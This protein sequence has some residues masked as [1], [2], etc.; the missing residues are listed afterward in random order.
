MNEGSV[1]SSHSRLI[2]HSVSTCCGPDTGNRGWH[3]EV[4]PRG[5][6]ARAD[7]Y[8][9]ERTRLTQPTQACRN[10]APGGG[11]VVLITPGLER[12]FWDRRGR[13]R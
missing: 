4:H 12:S 2:I 7:G 1:S 8:D 11:F 6:R 13:D 9:P 3:A 5:Q 10:E